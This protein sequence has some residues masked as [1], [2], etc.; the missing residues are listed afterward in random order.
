MSRRR[1]RALVVVGSLVTLLIVGEA[2]LVVAVFV[3]PSAGEHLR[4]VAASADRTWNG[5]K[6]REG[7]SSRIAG[8]VHR[9]YQDWI[10]SM[11]TS[12]SN[13]A[14]DT[15]F[16]R[17]VKCHSDYA[18]KRSFT[19]VYMNHPLHAQLGVACSMCHQQN[20][21]PDPMRPTEDTCK[22]C[23]AEVTSQGG[24]TLCHPPA[25]LPHFY[26]L[27]A[28]RD[29]VVECTVCHPK[30]SFT[31]TATTP[32]V[33]VG[34]FDGS[35]PGEC[36]A[37]HETSTCRQC[38]ATTHPPGWVSQHGAVV[39]EDPTPCYRCHTGDWCASR[40]HA[41]TPTNPFVPQPLPSIGVRP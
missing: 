2:A 4:S 7:V 27:G 18:Q 12:P 35:E 30:S 11:W 22:A 16:A 38:H 37:C 10:E 23:H 31:S 29:R 21:H 5:T 40:C 34:H 9:G 3:S 39:G 26:L 25:S 19:S 32:L 17:C 33:H 20:Q 28:P 36:T 15:E 8:A 1:S 6:H 13:P 24:C 14:P 41:V